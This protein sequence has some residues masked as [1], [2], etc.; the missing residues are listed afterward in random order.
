M[1]RL[2]LLASFVLGLQVIANAQMADDIDEAVFICASEVGI[3]MN[4]TNYSSDPSDPTPGCGDAITQ[5]GWFKVKAFNGGDIDVNFQNISSGDQFSVTV[6]RNN[7]GALGAE[8]IC[9]IVEQ[10]VTNKVTIT[11]TATGEEFFVMVDGE[12]S[13][14][15]NF[16]LSITGALDVAMKS[17]DLTFFTSRSFGSWQNNVVVTNT[18]DLH[19]DVDEFVLTINFIQEDVSCFN[20]TGWVLPTVVSINDGVNTP[21]GDVITGSYTI[22]GFNENHS[23]EL[24]S[25]FPGEWELILKP[26]NHNCFDAQFK[27]LTEKTYVQR[28]LAYRTTDNTFG[29]QLCGNDVYCDQNP[30]NEWYG[31]AVVLP[32]LTGVTANITSWTWTFKDTPANGGGVLFTKNSGFTSNAKNDEVEFDLTT[33]QDSLLNEKPYVVEISVEG[34]NGPGFQ[35]YTLEPYSANKPALTVSNPIVCISDI[36]A[37]NPL[38]FEV[39]NAQTLSP[40]PIAGMINWTIPAELGGSVKSGANEEILSFLDNSLLEPCTYTLIAEM[41]D[42]LGCTEVDSIDVTIVNQEF[43]NVLDTTN[44]NP[45]SARLQCEV[46]VYKK[47][48]IVE[49]IFQVDEVKS[50]QPVDVTVTFNG[51]AVPVI[52]GGTT[53][54]GPIEQTITTENYTVRV[55]HTGSV[56]DVIQIAVNK[57]VASIDVCPAIQTIELPRELDGGP[58]FGFSEPFCDKATSVTPLVI[59]IANAD[60]LTSPVSTIWL[61]FPGTEISRTATTISLIDVPAGEDFAIEAVVNYGIACSD[62]IDSVITIYQQPIIAFDTIT[63]DREE[64]LSEL[65]H[66]VGDEVEYKFNITNI[67]V[68]ENPVMTIKNLPTGDTSPEVLTTATYS[69]S[70]PITILNEPLEPDSTWIAGLIEVVTDNSCMDTLY[71]KIPVARHPLEITPDEEEVICTNESSVTLDIGVIYSEKDTVNFI[72]TSDD[73]TLP[74]EN[75][76]STITVDGLQE[77]QTYVITAEVSN[78][79]CTLTRNFTVSVNTSPPALVYNVLE[80]PSSLQTNCNNE[81]GFCNGQA[82]KIEFGSTTATEDYSILVNI[83]GEDGDIHDFAVGDPLKEI[84]YTVTSNPE[85]ITLKIWNTAGSEDCAV[86]E[87]VEVP[88]LQL[89][90][91][92][93]EDDG[94]NGSVVREIG[95]TPTCNASGFTFDWS[96]SD[97]EYLDIITNT[98]GNDVRNN[99]VTI[100]LT[101]QPDGMY[102][103]KVEVSNGECTQIVPININFSNSLPDGIEYLDPLHPGGVYCPEDLPANNHSLR[104]NFPNGGNGNGALR[105][106]WSST[107]DESKA[108]I[109]ENADLT[110]E[111]IP[112]NI[113]AGTAPGTY[114]FIAEVKERSSENE[115]TT[116]LTYSL[117]IIDGDEFIVITPESPEVC[118]FIETQLS[119]SGGNSYTWSKVDASGNETVIGT[120]STLDN[121]FHEE[122]GTHTYK[123]E[124]LENQCIEAG[125]F[126]L[127]VTDCDLFVPNVFTP[128]NGDDINQ[129]F[130]IPRISGRNWTLTVFNRYGDQVY[131][132]S[133]YDNSWSG[134]NLSDGMYYYHLKSKEGTKEFRGWV[135]LLKTGT[136]GDSR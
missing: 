131:K 25:H 48:D 114:E 70:I 19:G 108:L 132:N 120:G 8:V 11:G 134:K 60:S 52:K 33:A 93:G 26:I 105:I 23:V 118:T 63:T 13:N 124:D 90:E 61:Q 36:N 85:P 31:K 53:F 29:E 112:V 89:V 113:P 101:D 64:C 30:I 76:N 20:T 136:N 77:N 69:G 18:S 34:D 17:P 75:T 117:K 87:T 62:S 102:E 86:T 84:S 16:T 73:I 40:K 122:P 2:L 59:S 12:G 37:A 9:D 107:P 91:V 45:T 92:I 6:Y 57:Q 95:V 67:P 130:E 10:G 110:D 50:C 15:G 125:T 103:F 123:A 81:E 97:S 111:S 4:N 43:I 127:V 135:R 88:I 98:P 32:E 119:A 78:E 55:T 65:G 133:N 82:I 1:K 27:E 42:S 109:A 7:S 3:T 35:S 28:L 106:D 99:K 46:E 38:L 51:A 126:E 58:E 79:L 129:T 22:N 128:D 94:C 14:E 68:G 72:W 74:S 47:D 83:E 80:D 44:I 24:S 96:I 39:T 115:C 5:S 49:F 56:T 71:I 104:L 41:A 116:T 21:V 54:T 66:Q 121:L 100:D